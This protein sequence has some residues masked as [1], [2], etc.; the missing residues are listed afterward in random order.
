[1]ANTWFS[2]HSSRTTQNSVLCWSYL[3]LGFE[4]NKLK[5][6]RDKENSTK[7]KMVY[8][9]IIRYEEGNA[10]FPTA[11]IWICVEIISL[12]AVV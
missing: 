9:L 2:L 12:S 7:Q 11:V 5:L 8:F 4:S 1:M 3:S 10:I 6:K